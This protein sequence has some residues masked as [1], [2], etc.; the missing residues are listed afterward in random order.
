MQT[1]ITLASGATTDPFSVN[2]DGWVIIE[3]G[4]ATVTLQ[5]ST[6]TAADITSGVATWSSGGTFTGFSAVRVGEELSTAWVKLTASGGAITYHVEGE[7]SQADR[8][9]IRPYTKSVLNEV[10]LVTA[11]TNPVT[12][13]ISLSAGGALGVGMRDEGIV[14]PQTNL[15]AAVGAAGS[16]TGA[17]YYTAIFVTVDGLKSAP[18][19]GTATGVN[20]VSQQVNLTAIPVST[21]PRVVARW[22]YRTLATPTDVK[23]YRFLSI[24]LDN[25][26]TT[27]TD[28]TVDGS[29]GDPIDWLGTANGILYSSAGKV[30]SGLGKG[31]QAYA[32]GVETGSGYACT[33]VGYQT[34]KANTTGRRNTAVGVYSLT[35][36]TTGYE[37]TAIG[38]HSGGAVTVGIRNT[39]L[40]YQAGGATSSALDFNTAV[41]HSAFLGSGAS[42]GTGNTAIGYRALADINTADYCIAIGFSAGKYANAS[43]MLFIDNADR[44]TLANCQDIGIVYG[45]MEATA[46]AQRLNFNAVTRIGPP[47]VTVAALP[48]ATGLAGY[49]AFVTDANATTFASIVAGGGSN[50]V[51]VYCDG[52]NWRIG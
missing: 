30:I 9:T 21:D 3:A 7:L 41:G 51:P 10:A 37:N 2:P 40:G 4:A 15:I 42:K 23:D 19:P 22:I 26:T 47:S 28:N 29:L 17:Y 45:K 46:I 52:T 12:G 6:G 49:R 48:S 20:P 16:L 1:P 18:W 11:Q 25:T 13:G 32:S 38:T 34:L 24:I 31:S 33:S 14:E 27:Y 8:L 36:N 43:R 44:G 50:V 35:A 39:M 5:Y